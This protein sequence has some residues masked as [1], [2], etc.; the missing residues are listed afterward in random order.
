[1]GIGADGWPGLPEHLRQIVLDARVVLGGRR[2][3]DLLPPQPA[4]QR[5]TW[6]SPL[7]PQ[8]ADLVDSQ[9]GPVVALA[10]GDPLVS[11]VGST[12]IDL[13]GADRVRIHPSVSSVSLARAEMG[14]PAES[15]GVVSLVSGGTSR[16]LR[17][18]APRR[19]VIAL[20]ADERTPADVAEMLTQVGYGRSEMHVLGNLGAADFSRTDATADSWSGPAPRLNVIAVELLG[21]R[22]G[23][24]VPG[25]PDTLYDHDGDLPTRDLRACALARLCPTPGEHMWD[26]GA[27]A[28]AVAIEW[29]RTHPACS[30]TAIEAK[31]ERAE[32]I[33]RNARLLGVPDLRVVAQPAPEALEGLR[34]PDAVFIGGGATTPGLVDACMA[35]LRPGGRLVVHGARPE[36][37]RLLDELRS[38]HG[39]ELIR[40]SVETASPVGSDLMH[41]PVRP[42]SQWAFTPSA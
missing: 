29:M 25:L 6:A 9:E 21:P 2:H 28:G 18:L 38:L 4:Q 20:S 39:G 15:C 30:A 8:L 34:R 37:A 24:W 36:S 35:A 5:I 22:L 33:L 23:G 40:I 16:I 27:G 26:V 1:M 31:P 19:R 42:V 12:F 17:E 10:S 41:V 13:L 11:G 3:L 7:R 14:W 32:R